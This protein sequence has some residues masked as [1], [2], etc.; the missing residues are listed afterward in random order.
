MHTIVILISG[1]LELPNMHG[2][3]ALTFSIH[4]LLAKSYPLIICM[5]AIF[6]TLL[7]HSNDESKYP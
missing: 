6:Y 4:K 1:A 3:C 7:M 2:D 5:L